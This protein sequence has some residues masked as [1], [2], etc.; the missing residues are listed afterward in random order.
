MMPVIGACLSLILYHCYNCRLQRIE[1]TICWTK[2]AVW[3]IWF[4]DKHC[5]FCFRPTVYRPQHKTKLGET[6]CICRCATWMCCDACS[7]DVLLNV[8]KRQWMRRSSGWSYLIGRCLP[9][10]GNEFLLYTT[11]E[12]AANRLGGWDDAA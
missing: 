10:A 9:C 5:F 11:S 8:I 2:A 4:F 6:S 7:R 12:A 3:H 1:S